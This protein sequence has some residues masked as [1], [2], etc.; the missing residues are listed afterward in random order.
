VTAAATCS[1]PAHLLHSLYA[2]RSRS[3]SSR[4]IFLACSKERDL[5]LSTSCTDLAIGRRGSFSNSCSIRGLWILVSKSDNSRSLARVPHRLASIRRLRLYMKASAVDAETLK[6]QENRADDRY[7]NT[8]HEESFS[9][10][11]TKKSKK[12]AGITPI[13][14]TIERVCFL[15]RRQP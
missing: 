4:H 1:A 2:D 8:L 6:T 9:S 14:I 7:Q 15:F 12:V 13:N 11:Q 10:R 3:A 5:S